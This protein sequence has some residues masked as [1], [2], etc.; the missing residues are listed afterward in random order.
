[1]PYNIIRMAN[2]TGTK[3]LT[4]RMSLT[5]NVNYTYD[6]RYYVDL[7]YRVDG[8]SA[9]GSDKKYA[10]FWSAGIGWNL[11]REKFLENNNIIS[12]LR[13]K[14]S[15]GETGSMNVSATG[16][17]TTYEYS[18]DNKYMVWSGANLLGL[19]KQRDL[20]GRRLRRP[21]SVL[22]TACFKGRIRGTFDWYKKRTS[23]LLSYMDLPLS[24]GFSSYLAN[25]GEVENKGFET[26]LNVYLIRN[27]QKNLFW[28]IGGQ[29]TYNKNK[30]TKLSDAIKAQNDAYLKENVEV[31]N[32]FYEGRPQNGI[33]AVRSLGIDPSTGNEMFLGRDGK[34][35]DT[36]KASD[37]VY[38]GSSV[39]SYR[40]IANTML[41]WK[42]FTMNMSF[43]YYWGGKRYNSTLLNRVEVTSTQISQE[44]VDER[45]LTQRWTKPGDI[46]F[47]KRISDM[48]TRASS[49]FVMD[50]NVLE[51]QSVSLEYKWQDA[52]LQKWMHV[53]TLTF[54]LNMSDLW[55]TGSIKM[56]RG[57]S[58]PYARTVQGTLKFL[59]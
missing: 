14:A 23:N 27:T 40:G 20:R 31:S 25:V 28:T 53:Q 41:Q 46:V 15:Y 39:P 17:K 38:L 7:S 11:N 30:I 35:T 50:D 12:L 49:R 13:L 59:F 18:T 26:S 34:V 48:I 24:M 4:R 2:Q 47:F 8:S 1:M 16:A 56:E 22:N 29:L 45:V 19:G 21:T 6:N 51:L 44:N 3:T 42:G 36:W 58:Y 32:L 5:G 55:H 9:F 57:I 54:G 43:S 33:Y 37:K 10:P 52:W